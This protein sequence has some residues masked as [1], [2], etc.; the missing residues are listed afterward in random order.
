MAKDFSWAQLLHLGTNMWVDRKM[1]LGEELGQYGREY[2]Y[3]SDELRFD[4]SLWREVT[5]EMKDAGFNMVIIDLGEGLVYPSHPE[6]AIKGSW[7]AEKMRAE[8]RRLRALGLEP[9]PKLNF[10]ACHDIWLGEYEKMLSTPTYRTVCAE[11]IADVCEIFEKPRYFHLG[12]DEETASQQ[13]IYDYVAVRAPDLWWQD[14]LSHVRAVER[15]GARAMI[16]GDACWCTPSFHERLPK[17]VLPMNWYYWNDVREIADKTLL[18]APK[19]EKRPGKAGENHIAELRGFV[20]LERAG[21]DQF[22]CCSN[23]DNDGNMAAIVEY[24][25]RV[26][27]PERLKGFLFAPWA[28][29]IRKWGAPEKIRD[30]IRLAWEIIREG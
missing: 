27:A 2:N 3:L 22:P 7:S 11:L 28:L 30:S 14:L 29:T 9:V 4:E 24:C 26:V 23:W 10:S 13:D 15:Q 25:R 20:E 17:S 16:W 18:P 19:D 6:L 1:R 12:M 5:A 21:F 8:C